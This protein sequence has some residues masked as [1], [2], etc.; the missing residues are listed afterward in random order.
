MDTVC[1]RP[2]TLAGSSPVGLGEH[3]TCAR[4]LVAGVCCP[5]ALLGRLVPKDRRGH[6]AGDLRVEFGVTPVAFVRPRVA[7]VCCTVTLVGDFVTTVRGGI[8]FFGVSLPI[9]HPVLLKPRS[10]PPRAGYASGPLADGTVVWEWQDLDP[11]SYPAF[12]TR[13]P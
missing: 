1:C 12:E 7:E 13:Y 11:G 4:Q 8:P 9:R 6:Q 3:V 10:Y 5:V 2:A